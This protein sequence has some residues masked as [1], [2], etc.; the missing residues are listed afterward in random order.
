MVG[1]GA[2]VE[3]RITSCRGAH[4][5]AE[6]RGLGTPRTLH[7]RPPVFLVN[8][9]PFVPPPPGRWSPLLRCHSAEI[10]IHGFRDNV[11]QT[12]VSHFPSLSHLSGY[13]TRA[14]GSTGRWCFPRLWTKRQLRR[15]AAPC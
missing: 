13:L 8:P 14:S 12:R 3:L 5:G 11:K 4:P 15:A 9:S 2:D 7:C 10:Q 1:S 6:N